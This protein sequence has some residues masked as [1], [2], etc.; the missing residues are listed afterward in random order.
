MHLDTI[1][2]HVLVNQV[3]SASSPAKPPVPFMQLYQVKVM[4]N[5]SNDWVILQ[6]QRNI[7]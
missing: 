5:Q 3:F 6:D 1:K 7:Y 4:N 2:S